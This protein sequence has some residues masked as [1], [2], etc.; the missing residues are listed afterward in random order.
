MSTTSPP[1]SAYNAGAK[2]DK[3]V[4][5]PAADPVDP[6]EVVVGMSELSFAESGEAVTRRVRVSQVKQWRLDFEAVPNGGKIEVSYAYDDGAFI[7][8]KSGEAHTPNDKE[9]YLFFKLKLTR[10]P[11]GKVSPALYGLKLMVMKKQ[12]PENQGDIDGK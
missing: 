7:P 9:R 11:E 4:L 5:T 1:P 12:A 10:A 2:L 6:Q 3:I 8:L